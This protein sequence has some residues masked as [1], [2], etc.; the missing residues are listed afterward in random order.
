VCDCIGMPIVTPENVL[1]GFFA[2]ISLLPVTTGPGVGAGARGNPVSAIGFFAIV[3]K[4]G[5]GAAPKTFP[6]GTSLLATA[7]NCVPEEANNCELDGAARGFGRG[8]ETAPSVSST[9]PSTSLASL[10]L[11][12]RAAYVGKGTYARVSFPSV[13]DTGGKQ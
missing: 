7:F 3:F 11:S 4:D 13:G 6:R 2:I 5:T 12:P 1:I 8:A 10:S 9:P